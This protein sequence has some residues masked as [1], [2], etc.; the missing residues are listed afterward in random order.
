MMIDDRRPGN[1]LIYLAAVGLAFAVAASPRAARSGGLDTEAPAPAGPRWSNAS[2]HLQGAAMAGDCIAPS[3]EYRAEYVPG[4]DAW[5]RPVIPAETARAPSARPL[6]GEIDVHLKH[7][8]LAG[9]DIDL[10]AVAPIQ[11]APA[12]GGAIPG[13][14][15]QDC[16][17]AFK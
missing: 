13:A 8:R 9:R 5:G 14:G 10:S 7:K 15:G 3:A 4:I 16:A 2:H 12:P 17:Q 6:M 11:L 1:I